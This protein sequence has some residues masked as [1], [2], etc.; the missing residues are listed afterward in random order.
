M[1]ATIWISGRTCRVIVTNNGNVIDLN[2]DW[3]NIASAQSWL[4]DY[5]PEAAQ[6]AIRD[7]SKIKELD[8]EWNRCKLGV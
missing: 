7:H 6:K 4:Y 8:A 1:N 3:N 5:Y 2:D